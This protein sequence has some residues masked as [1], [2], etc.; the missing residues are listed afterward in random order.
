MYLKQNLHISGFGYLCAA[1]HP[2]L[3]KITSNIQFLS[4]RSLQNPQSILKSGANIEECS[5][6]EAAQQ[7]K[8]IRYIHKKYVFSKSKRTFPEEAAFWQML[9]SMYKED[10]ETIKN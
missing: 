3:R 7:K 2:A 8:A 9:L 10:Y 6:A 4:N 5:T 1:K